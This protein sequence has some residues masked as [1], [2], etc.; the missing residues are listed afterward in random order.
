MDINIKPINSK[1]IMGSAIKVPP[2]LKSAVIVED[3]IAVQMDLA[4][5]LSQQTGCPP[6]SY[7]SQKFLEGE[8]PDTSVD[9]M[10]IGMS[11]NKEQNLQLLE[12]ALVQ[13]RMVICL[14]TS[15]HPFASE[16]PIDR[17]HILLKP[18][19]PAELQALLQLQH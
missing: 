1:P 12:K 15:Q 10:V 4:D 17:V 14:V 5:I 2:P 19:D 7:S 18:H 16:T 11:S 6:D 3:D 9:V 8:A 13:A